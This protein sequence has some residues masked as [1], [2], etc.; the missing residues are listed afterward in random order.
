MLYVE[1][2]NFMNKRYLLSLLLLISLGLANC[3]DSPQANTSTINLPDKAST[4]TISSTTAIA[5][6]VA[7][8]TATPVATTSSTASATTSPTAT[9]TPV[10]ISTPPATD[11]IKEIFAQAT[12][13]KDR[14]RYL[15]EQMKTS[16]K[17]AKQRAVL[18][19]VRKTTDPACARIA[20]IIENKRFSE[21]A[22]GEIMDICERLK[23]ALVA[24]DIPKL[25]GVLK[26]FNPVYEH[27][28]KAAN[29]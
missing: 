20:K 6:D 22:I 13:I 25:Q 23:E 24:K 11:D 14:L 29:K 15:S 2:I 12:V 7:T 5:T 21:P 8:P 3:A 9:P 18:A 27:L 1:A 4:K 17:P 10:A 28:E 16:L 26:D 19:D